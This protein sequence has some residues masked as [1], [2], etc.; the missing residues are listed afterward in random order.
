MQLLGTPAGADGHAR[1]PFFTAAV[2]CAAV[3]RVQRG[4]FVAA[5]SSRVQRGQFVAAVS[6]LQ[7]SSLAAVFAAIRWLFWAVPRVQRGHFVAAVFLLA[8]VFCAVPLF[9][10]TWEQPGTIPLVCTRTVH[11]R[12]SAQL[13]PQPLLS[14]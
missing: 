1:R 11:K 6:L 7:F 5:V 10:S 14:L 2:F 13:G 12:D 4:Q 9:P 8:T 3:S